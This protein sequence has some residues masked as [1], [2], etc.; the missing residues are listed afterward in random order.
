[1]KQDYQ[2]ISIVFSSLSWFQESFRNDTF[3]SSHNAELP[4]WGTEKTNMKTHPDC[5]HDC[6]SD[7]RREGCNCLCGEFHGYYEDDILQQ[8]N[9]KSDVMAESLKEESV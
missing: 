3:H 4:T 2:I 6:T 1:M 8:E 5:S 9:E 7:C